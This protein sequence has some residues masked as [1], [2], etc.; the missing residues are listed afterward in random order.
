M[1]PAVID[2]CPHVSWV[3][4]HTL[5]VELIARE[6]YAVPMIVW[7]LLAEQHMN[8]SMLKVQV[9]VATVGPNRFTS[10]EEVATA[11]HHVM[12]GEESEKMMKRASELKEKLEHALSKVGCSTQALAQITDT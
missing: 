7:P 1:G 9:W 11:I 3:L 8:A 12:E 10:K 4:R 6:Y 5:R 2:T